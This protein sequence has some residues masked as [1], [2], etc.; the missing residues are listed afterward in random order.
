MGKRVISG[1]ALDM[2]DLVECLK[3]VFGKGTQGVVKFFRSSVKSGAVQ[4]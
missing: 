3:G 2:Y 4:G 1:N